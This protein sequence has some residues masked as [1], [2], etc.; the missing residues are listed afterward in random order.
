MG[1]EKEGMVIKRRA[2]EAW[3]SAEG[4]SALGWEEME[5]GLG[6]EMLQRCTKNTAK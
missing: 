6:L 5:L 3:E 4:G 2:T 1:R